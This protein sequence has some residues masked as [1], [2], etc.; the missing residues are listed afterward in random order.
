MQRPIRKIQLHYP[1]LLY[2]SWKCGDKDTIKSVR[3]GCLSCRLTELYAAR[4]GVNLVS[5]DCFTGKDYL[6]CCPPPW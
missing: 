3:S 4:Q 1:L 5:A 2:G 6:I